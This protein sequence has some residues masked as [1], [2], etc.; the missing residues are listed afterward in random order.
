MTDVTASIEYKI[1][2]NGEIFLLD[3][4]KYHLIEGILD[5]GSITKAAKQVDISYR[6]ALN[7]I[8]KIEDSLDI[9][10]VNTIK[11]GKGGGG[12]ASLTPE[13]YSI[14]KECKKFNAMLSLH[15][16]VNEIE[17]VVTSIDDIN[18]HC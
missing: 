6:T 7:Y 5:T 15:K 13:G 18:R 14:L 3:S 12:G 10:L 16:R 1:N 8:D 4:K 17:S 11:G 2:L 9:K